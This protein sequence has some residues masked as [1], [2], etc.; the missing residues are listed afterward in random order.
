[1]C[2]HGQWNIVIG[3]TWRWFWINFSQ[4][5]M[6]WLFWHLQFPF[7]LIPTNHLLLSL[8]LFHASLAN[9]D[10]KNFIKHFVKMCGWMCQNTHFGHISQCWKMQFWNILILLWSFEKMFQTRNLR[11]S[12]RNQGSRSFLQMPLDL[13]WVAGWDI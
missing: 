8:R 5:V 6:I 4:G 9:D 1:M 12:C 3:L 7:L 10:Y 13:W 11:Q 2:W